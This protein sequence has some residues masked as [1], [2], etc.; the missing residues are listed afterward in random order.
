MAVSG[1]IVDAYKD[2]GLVLTCSAAAA[3]T[4]GNLVVLT[5]NSFEVTVAGAGAV[6]ACG[7]ALRTAGEAGD[8]IPVAFPGSQVYR[9]TASGAID[10]GSYVA[11][12]ASGAVAAVAADG[13]PRLIVGFALE[14]IASGEAGRVALL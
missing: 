7:V 13:D 1:G 9:L 12:A 8:K 4:A 11:A 14:D 2:G 10:A 3:I 6:K 5:A